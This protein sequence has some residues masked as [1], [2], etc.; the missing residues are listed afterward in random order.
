M[1]RFLACV[2]MLAEIA[3]CC[4]ACRWKRPLRSDD[5]VDTSNMSKLAVVNW[6]FSVYIDYIQYISWCPYTASDVKI[7]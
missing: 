3:L 5:I 2:K 4:I 6:S 1:Q 7:T